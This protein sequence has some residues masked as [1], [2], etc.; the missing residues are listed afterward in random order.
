MQKTK[1]RNWWA[2]ILLLSVCCI[3]SYQS[4][5]AMPEAEATAK[6]FKVGAKVSDLDRQLKGWNPSWSDVEE[7]TP[8]SGTKTP[9]DRVIKNEFGEFR[10]ASKGSYQDWKLAL[11]RETF[12]GTISFHHQ[13]W[14][15]P[16]EF[17]PSFTIEL[18]YMNGTLRKVLWGFLP[19]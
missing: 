8:V 14:V 2:F 5:R 16:D 11:G 18:T 15:I 9:G 19:G 1:N 17:K 13:S 10:A 6:R 12:R 7:W 4:C 3:L